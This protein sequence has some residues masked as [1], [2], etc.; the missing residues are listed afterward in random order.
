M[1]RKE[2]YPLFDKSYQLSIEIFKATMKFPKSQRYVI[3]HRLQDCSLKFIE[4]ITLCFTLKDKLTALNR[5]SDYLERLRILTRV[6][7]ELDFWSFNYY[8]RINLQI[9]E[10]G[11]MLGGWIKREKG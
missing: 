7:L 8:E 10:I 11:K 6:T 5:A 9:N 4:E 1:K 3:S 2:D